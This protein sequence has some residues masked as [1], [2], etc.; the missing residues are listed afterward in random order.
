MTDVT[1]AVE[2]IGAGEVET[3]D[4]DGAFPRLADEQL[5]RLRALG[6]VR[7]VEAGEILFAEGDQGSD[8]FIVESGSIAIVQGYGKENRVMAIHGPRRFT[9]ELSM[10]TGQRLYLA[11]AARGH[12]PGQDAQ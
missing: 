3:P 8:F 12:R 11:G 5:A 2:P 9:G 1:G 10:I 6:R 4:R 7:R